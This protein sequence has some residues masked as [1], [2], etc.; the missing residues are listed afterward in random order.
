MTTLDTIKTRRSIRSFQPQQIPDD[1]LQ[2]ILE[3]GTYAPSGRGRQAEKIV[4]IQDK[5]LIHRLSKLNAT[6][7]P[8]SSIDPFYGAPTVVVVLVHKESS[9]IIEDGSAVLMN[10]L[11]AAHSLGVASC[12]IHRAKEEFESEEGQSI[13]K[14]IGLNNEYVGVGHCLLGYATDKTA[15]KPAPRKPSC[16]MIIK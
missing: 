4:A 6:F 16:T 1:V 3:A 11:T 14:E 9:T 13:L 2:Q 12:W 7:L 10:M 8:N 15:P 5:T